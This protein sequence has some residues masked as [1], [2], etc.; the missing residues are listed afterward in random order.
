MINNVMDFMSC[1]LII[2]E[3]LNSTI[4]EAVIT[5]LAFTEKPFESYSINFVWINW[6]L[7]SYDIFNVDPFIRW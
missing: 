5:I 2:N 3:L 7:F 1:F 6:S 4:I